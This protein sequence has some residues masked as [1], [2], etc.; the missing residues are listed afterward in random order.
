MLFEND[1]KMYGTQASCSAIGCLYG[2]ENDVKMYGT[3]AGAYASYLTRS[4]LR[5]M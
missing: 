4:G 1:V 3:Q 2:F 5:M